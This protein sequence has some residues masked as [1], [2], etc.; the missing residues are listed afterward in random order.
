MAKI[1]SNLIQALKA[2]LEREYETKL[3]RA[4]LVAYCKSIGDAAACTG[5]LSGHRV[6]MRRKHSATEMDRIARS[7]RKREVKL[8]LPLLDRWPP[9]SDSAPAPSASQR[10]P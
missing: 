5:D 3:T 9:G 4:E 7:S 1:R 2:E 8:D 10:Q 6:V